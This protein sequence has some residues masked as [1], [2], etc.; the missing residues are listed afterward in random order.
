M[1]ILTTKQLE[2]EDRNYMYS[3]YFMPE[4]DANKTNTRK[5]IKNISA[6]NKDKEAEDAINKL[7]GNIENLNTK[8]YTYEHF[9]E[10]LGL[11]SLSRGEALMLVSY[12]AVVSGEQ[13]ILKYDIKQ[14]TKTSKRIYYNQFKD[15][16]NIII[17]V[18]NEQQ[19]EAL[20]MIMKGEII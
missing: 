19:A 11:D 4:I 20:E 18:D 14:L 5:L 3:E 10:E 6:L 17:L 13:I 2:T 8:N 15:N 16:N 12:A 9:N 7:G 1:R